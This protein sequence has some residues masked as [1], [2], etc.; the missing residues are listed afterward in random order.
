[1]GKRTRTKQVPV[2]KS[3]FEMGFELKYFA[4]REAEDRAAVV[5]AHR[6]EYYIFFF[7]QSGTTKLMVDFEQVTLQGR[8]MGV[9]CPGQVHHYLQQDSAGWFMAVDTT[10]VNDEWRT[11]LENTRGHLQYIEVRK[12]DRYTKC[13]E[14]IA[15]Q[16]QAGIS[17]VYQRKVIHAL[18]NAYI[19]MVATA[20]YEQVQ[21][22]EKNFS[23]GSTVTRQ[24]KQLVKEH[25]ITVK[26][27]AAYAGM[28]NLSLS[29]LNELVK[30]HTGYPVSYWIQQECILEAKRLL[31]YTDLNTKEISYKTGYEDHTYFSRVFKKIIGQTPL[32]FRA[33]YRELSNQSH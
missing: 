18:V 21:T 14:L 10:L 16:V 9:V 7:Q 30:A 3:E 12:D 4:R 15:A 23:R 26:S 17:G 33:K 20:F 6:D 8:Q 13:I 24:F 28:L 2:H 31:Y 25:Y 27:P 5:G 29:Y 32:E 11:I 1:M 19:G 22:S